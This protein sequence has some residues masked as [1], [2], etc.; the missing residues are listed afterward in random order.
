MI[1]IE[2]VRSILETEFDGITKNE[3]VSNNTFWFVGANE[4]KITVRA[5]GFDYYV[6]IQKNGFGNTVMWLVHYEIVDE[7]QLRQSICKS[8]K[9]IEFYETL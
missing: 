6:S 9:M 5:T 4:A 3:D 1:S 2:A 8:K 7:N